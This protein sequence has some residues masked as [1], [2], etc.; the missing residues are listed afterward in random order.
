MTDTQ[1][2]A[3]TGA[4]AD[5]DRDAATRDLETRELTPFMAPLTVPPVLRP[6]GGDV[7]EETEI[8]VRSAWVRLHPQ[9]PPTL[10]WGYEGSVPGPTIEVRRGERVRIAWTNR[11]PKDSEFPVTAVE[12]PRTSPPPST[13]PGRDGVEPN[14]D[15]AALPAWT[16]TLPQALNFVRAG[17]APPTARRRAAGTTAG[18]TTPW[19][20]ATP[21]CRSIRTTTRRSSGGITTTP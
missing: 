21:S 16:V 2:G 3:R 13:R 5:I 12:A 14:K 4:H 10:M 9:L 11:V 18:R 15:V 19:G 17:E 1:T 8:A 6:A 20:T 7:L